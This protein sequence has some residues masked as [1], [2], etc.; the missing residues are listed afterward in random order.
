[1]NG[2]RTNKKLEVVTT[3]CVRS[4]TKISYGIV[5]YRYYATT[6]MHYAHEDEE[7]KKR[8]TQIQ[9]QKD[10]VSLPFAPLRLQF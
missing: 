10:F 9:S 3:D 2:I 8:D 4:S 1:M 6:S 7:R 5:F